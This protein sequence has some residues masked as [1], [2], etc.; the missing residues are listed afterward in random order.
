VN[1][2][3]LKI[4]ARPIIYSNGSLSAKAFRKLEPSARDIGARYKDGA[5]SLG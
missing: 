2:A 4:I 3:E 5:H 1:S